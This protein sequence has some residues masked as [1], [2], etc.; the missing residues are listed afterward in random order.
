MDSDIEVEEI[1][2]VKM[3]CECCGGTG[4]A[5]CYDCAG[6][7]HCRHC[8]AHDNCPECHGAAKLTCDECDGQ[9]WCMEQV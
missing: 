8:E 6:L 2:W 3:N 1:V 7:G 5:D 9:G 4:M